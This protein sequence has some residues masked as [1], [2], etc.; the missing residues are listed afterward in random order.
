M[1][2]N[3]TVGGRL[4]RRE[5]LRL[6][7]AAGATA[8]AG[9]GDKGAL[10][11]RPA[12]QPGSAAGASSLPDMIR[13]AVFSPAPRATRDVSQLSCVTR[14]SLTEGP[15]FVDERLNRADIRSDP[16]NGT[17]KAGVPLK[18]KF[19]VSRVG[20][21][22]CTAL[23][24]AFVDLWHCDAAGGYSDVSGQG[25][26][27][28]A[29]QKFLRGYQVTDANGAAEFTTIYPGWYSGRTVHLH[30]KVRLFAGST[31]TYEFTSQLCFD[32]ALTDQVFTQAPYNTRGTR[33]TR[34]NNDMIY[35]SAGATVLLSLTSDGAG[36]YLTSYDIGLSN[37][38]DAVAGVA[39]VSAA[40]FASGPL[41][42]E[43][44]AAL[45]GSSLATGT[46]SATTT[47]LPTELEGV[48]VFVR[49]SVGTTRTAPLFFVSPTQI[50]FQIPSGTVAG[51]AVIYVQRGG[52]AVGQ[53]TA[54]IETVAPALF[55][56]NANGQG[57]PAAVVQRVKADGTQSFEAAVQFD[58]AQGRFVPAAIDLGPETDRLF[59]VGFGTGFRNRSALPAVTASIGGTNAEVLFAGAQGG[60]AGLDQ[61]NIAIPRSLAGRGDVDLIFNV[62]G[63]AA[64]TVSLNIR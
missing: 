39:A 54:A 27:N 40:S 7:G 50:N 33:N 47:P 3:R 51:A 20:G 4:S 45:Y 44:I 34:N 22:S 55:T 64:N 17:V 1:S 11:L 29:G 32:D 53:G 5:T 6:L 19:N 14:P 61:A 31:R 62:D 25:N 26:P 15:F 24:G 49:D 8:F 38:P 48:Q 58:A 28:N 57:A 41:A 10:L 60:F 12:G 63:K 37:V 2:M 36:G 18:I 13:N 35:Q 43:A 46:A 16:S 59:L 52:A 21:G 23:A 9:W 42:G 56:A 30:Y